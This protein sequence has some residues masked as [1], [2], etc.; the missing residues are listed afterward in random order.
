MAEVGSIDV[1]NPGLAFARQA[2]MEAQLLRSAESALAFFLSAVKTKAMSR[3]LY[4][5]Q[6]SSLWS[7]AVQMILDD[8]PAEAAEY[9][10]SDFEE[11]DIPTDVYSATQAVLTAAA[12][13]YASDSALSQELDRVLS[14]NGFAVEQINASAG[15]LERESSLDATLREARSLTAASWWDSLQET[16]SV[17]IKRIRRTTRT[18]ATGLNSVITITAIR[19]QDYSHKRWVTRHD[20]RVRFTHK[21]ADG[22]TVPRD[23]PFLVGGYT[24]RFPGD[25]SAEYGEVVNCRCTLIGVDL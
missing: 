5:P 14:V 17:W 18:S 12:Q 13:A 10:R 3:T 1:S 7:M 6:V 15:W 4:P 23:M 25:R 22:Q 19:L 20:D 16:G 2:G 24:L 9:V 21:L 8:L 11:S